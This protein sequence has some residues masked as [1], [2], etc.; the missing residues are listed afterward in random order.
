[1]FEDFTAASGAVEIPLVGGRKR[2]GG[3]WLVIVSRQLHCYEFC[4]FAVS[5]EEQQSGAVPGG[6]GVP[7]CVTERLGE[8]VQAAAFQ[9][10][11]VVSA[12]CV[13]IGI[14]CRIDYDMLL[15]V[16]AA[17]FAGHRTQAQIQ[18]ERHTFNAS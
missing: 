14:R 10:T 15:L 16:K 1:M 13:E 11:S 9:K 3:Q 5:S 4:G 2:H 6:A 12:I 8:V 7:Q 18:A 17:R